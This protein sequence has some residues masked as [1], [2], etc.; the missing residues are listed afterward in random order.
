MLIIINGT[1]RHVAA[2]PPQNLIIP[3]KPDAMR[4]WEQLKKRVK[5]DN[6]VAI[7]ERY[8]LTRG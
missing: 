7:L 2:T 4:A 6:T 1:V 3:S 5:Q 8:L